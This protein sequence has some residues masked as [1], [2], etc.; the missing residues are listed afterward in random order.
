MLRRG[1]VCAFCSICCC[2]APERRERERERGDQRSGEERRGG[3]QMW[4][5]CSWDLGVYARDPSFSP[6]SG[7]S[8]ATGG[9]R[10]VHRDRIKGGS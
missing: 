1:G 3:Q 4:H 2:A 5:A 7:M 10:Y 8:T 6:P 9:E